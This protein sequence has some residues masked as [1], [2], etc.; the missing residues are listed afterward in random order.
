MDE[1]DEAIDDTTFEDWVFEAIDGLPVAFRDRL[2]SVAI[3]IEEWPTPAQLSSVGARGLYGLYQGVPRSLPGADHAATPSKITIF[4][5][6]LE[7]N[8]RT[9][10]ALRA[11]VID[12]VHHEIAH[13]FGISDARLVELAA[14]HDHGTAGR[15]P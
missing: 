9:P 3:V 6:Q 10:Q 14:E 12:T 11:K 8:F 2:G 5:G 4:R 15:A 13:H 1:K 7:R